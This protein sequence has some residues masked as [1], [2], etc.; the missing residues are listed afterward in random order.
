MSKDH[1]PCNA[2]GDVHHINDLDAKPPQLAG[3]KATSEMIA[4]AADTGADFTVLECA[5]CYRPA[6]TRLN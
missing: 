2:C 6:Y 5:K 3:I 1:F 4:E